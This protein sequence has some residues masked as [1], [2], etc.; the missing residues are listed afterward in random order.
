[1]LG[2]ISPEQI[3]NTADRHVCGYFRVTDVND[4]TTHVQY[5]N[6]KD[7]DKK[8]EETVKSISA[9][10]DQVFKITF[11]KSMSGKN[12]AEYCY[13]LNKGS[14][15]VSTPS[16]PQTIINTPFEPA[17]TMSEALKD[18]TAL[19]E[20]KA[21]NKRLQEELDRMKMQIIRY[22]EEEDDEEIDP[23][24]SL[25]RLKERLKKGRM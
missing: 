17:R 23:L 14:Q 4:T 12:K 2:T 9:I 20:T 8:I 15:P 22:E 5:G 24:S 13:Y 11:C 16:S 25:A 10:P 19:A 1:M 7:L 6:K 3:K 18:A 21:E